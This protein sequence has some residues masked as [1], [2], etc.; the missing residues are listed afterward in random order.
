MLCSDT[1]TTTQRLVCFDRTN[2]GRLSAIPLLCLHLKSIDRSKLVCRLIS[3]LT[4]G[5]DKFVQPCQDKLEREMSV[6]TLSH[7][8]KLG[9]DNCKI[10]VSST[11]G[12]NLSRD[13]C[14]YRNKLS[15]SP[16]LGRDNS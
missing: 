8:A 7:R 2:L 4:G 5:Q 3:I 6:F 10:K 12:S 1:W 15:R 9:R 16:K 11:S 14:H 13:N